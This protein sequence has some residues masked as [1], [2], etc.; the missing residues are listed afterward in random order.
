MKSVE[1][2]KQ[3]RSKDIQILSKDLNNEYKKLQEL[4]FSL[5]FRKLKNVNQ[6]KKC[7]TNIARIMTIINEKL[8]KKISK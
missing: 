6:I 7:K 1:D 2:L 8:D 3:F 4:R 5:K